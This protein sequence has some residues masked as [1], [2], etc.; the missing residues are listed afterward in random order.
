M[1]MPGLVYKSFP[2]SGTG[3]MTGTRT[4]GARSGSS[5]W[6]SAAPSSCG[7]GLGCKGV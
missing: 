7:V 1:V 5:C 4:G 6:G 3:R 2:V